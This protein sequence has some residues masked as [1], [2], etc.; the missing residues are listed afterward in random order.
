MAVAELGVPIYITETG[1]ADA[2]GDRR[3]VFLDTYVP[4][5][6]PGTTLHGFYHRSRQASGYVYHTRAC[7][8]RA[9]CALMVS[10]TGRR[11][12]SS[13]IH[14]E[15]RRGHLA[16]IERAVSDGY[17]VRGL[18]VWTLIDN[19]EVV[20]I[21]LCWS[22]ILSCGKVLH[23]NAISRMTDCASMF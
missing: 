18:M 13:A 10:C 22:S 2:K 12:P 15:L 11:W 8:I 1:I 16:Q 19:F 21:M 6:R 5:V 9:A 23:I 20:P 3:A 17:D 4:Q 7:W 14:S